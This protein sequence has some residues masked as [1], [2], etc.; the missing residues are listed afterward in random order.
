MRSSR[1]SQARDARCLNGDSIDRCQRSPLGV[2]KKGGEHIYILLSFLNNARCLA[3]PYPPPTTTRTR[4]RKT[5]M[6]QNEPR[7]GGEKLHS[8]YLRKLGLPE[9]VAWVVAGFSSPSGPV[10][11]V[12]G[13]SPPSFSLLL[14]AVVDTESSRSAMAS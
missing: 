4:K 2:R 3:S 7:E 5:K 8:T 13:L 9:E 12:D 14:A 10:V 1:T 11:D 6:K